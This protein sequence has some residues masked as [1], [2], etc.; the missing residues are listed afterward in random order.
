MKMK[1]DKSCMQHFVTACVM[2][3]LCAMFAGF[4]ADVD[5]VKGPGT[6]SPPSQMSKIINISFESAVVTSAF[7]GLAGLLALSGGF[8]NL[9]N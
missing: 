5:L 6:T 3:A 7:F 8:M 2:F 1:F 9:Y 4:A